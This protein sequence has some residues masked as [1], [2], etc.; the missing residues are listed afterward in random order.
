[1]SHLAASIMA[2][3]PPGRAH[4]PR[5]MTNSVQFKGGEFRCAACRPSGSSYVRG[6]R[7]HGAAT[8]AYVARSAPQ[9]AADTRPR[10][11]HG[12]VLLALVP[13]TELVVGDHGGSHP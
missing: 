11:A 13:G 9:C 6:A 1:M 7:P 8:W 5:R 2:A 3:R 10:R 4:R 12:L